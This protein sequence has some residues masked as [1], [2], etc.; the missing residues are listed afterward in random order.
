MTLVSA[1]ASRQGRI[2]SR[3]LREKLL[4]VGET[5]GRTYFVNHMILWS[6]GGEMAKGSGTVSA[7]TSRISFV[8]SA[9]SQVSDLECLAR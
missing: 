5:V 3:R 7:T 2:S 4:D 8:R 9:M 1:I 6:I